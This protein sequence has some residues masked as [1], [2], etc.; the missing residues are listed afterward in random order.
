MLVG[1]VLSPERTRTILDRTSQWLERPANDS[2]RR[3]VLGLRLDLLIAL[4]DTDAAREL[5]LPSA[6]A[7]S[8]QRAGPPR[9]SGLG[10][11]PGQNGRTGGRHA[12]ATN[13]VI[14]NRKP[15]QQTSR[16]GRGDG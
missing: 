4:G 1:V 10:R 2:A 8:R 11:E 13:A 9:G 16:G 5:A 12:L 7:G 3:A 14:A 15:F 6:H